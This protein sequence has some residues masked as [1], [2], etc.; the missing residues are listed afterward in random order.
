MITYGWCLD[1]NHKYTRLKDIAVVPLGSAKI[2]P[3][4]ETQHFFIFSKLV[5][6]YIPEA[7]FI[8]LAI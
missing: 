5:V 4:Y 2:D 8:K 6:E 3:L 7:R 1:T